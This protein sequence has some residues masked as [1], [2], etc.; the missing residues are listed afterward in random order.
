MFSKL[1]AKN[2]GRS[3]KDYGVW[4]LTIV[5]AVCLFYVF[6]ALETQAVFQYLGSG[7]TAPTAQAIRELVGMLSVFVWVVLAFLIL[8][9]S[10]FL[11]R[12]R[13]KELGTYLL[14][15][16]GRGQEEDVRQACLAL[17][18]YPGG[19][20][21]GGGMN[22]ENAAFFLDKGASHVIVTSFVFKDGK[23]NYDNLK[24]MVKVTGRE[25]L[26]LDLSCR[27]KDGAYYIVTDRWQKFTDVKLTEAVL[28]ELSGYC[29]EFLIHA[30]DVE[31]KSN[32][33]EEDIAALLGRWDGIPVTY[34][35]GV[36]SM[37][38]L[39]RLKELGRGRVDVTIGSA[40]DLFGGPL[41]FEDVLGEMER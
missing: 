31:G 5:F 35:G 8:Y 39:R 22:D 29:D 1:A 38:D 23:I 12:R 10:G 16:M 15:G 14:L 25:R 11:I 9:A 18:A 33:I 24:K 21:I 6:N 2:V 30:V 41:R 32:G 20:Q 17:A 19:L 34:A 7:P 13:K 3:V 37:E 36:G 4:F 40:L 26:V 28:E 27:R